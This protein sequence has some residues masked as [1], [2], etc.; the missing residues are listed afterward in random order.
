M[1]LSSYLK[2]SK[3]AQLPEAP[4]FK[5]WEEEGGGGWGWNLLTLFMY[6]FLPMS[7]NCISYPF[8]LQFCSVEGLLYV[9]HAKGQVMEASTS[10]YIHSSL[11]L[12]L[13]VSPFELFCFC[14]LM[15]NNCTMKGNILGC[16]NIITSARC[17]CIW[18]CAFCPRCVVLLYD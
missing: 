1:Y 5:C 17:D 9:S 18:N 11:I 15:W 10:L 8:L 3:I 16:N 2:K 13:P 6:N 4:A 14:V 7:K 12:F